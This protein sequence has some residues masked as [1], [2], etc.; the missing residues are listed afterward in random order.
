[1][2]ST[3]LLLTELKDGVKEQLAT[4][5]I[6]LGVSHPVFDISMIILTVI[7]LPQSTNKVERNLNKYQFIIVFVFRDL[8]QQCFCVTSMS[9]V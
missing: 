5:D 6:L 1:M 7:T 2:V 4:Q 9:Y 3:W 8:C